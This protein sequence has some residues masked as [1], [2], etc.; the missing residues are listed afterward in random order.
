M[1]TPSWRARVTTRCM[2]GRAPTPWSA[3]AATTTYVFGPLTQG[4]VTVNDGSSTNNTLDFS[5]FSAGINLDLQAV[6]PQA[7]SPG[8][9]NLTLTN[10][11]SINQV[12]GTSYPDTIL[13]NGRNDT[14]IGNGGADYLNARGGAALIEGDETQVV[15]LDFLPGAIDYSAQTT[16]DAIQAQIGAIY[17]AFNFTFTQTQPTSGAVRDALFQCSRRQSAGRR[18]DGARLA[19][20]RPGRLSLDR[21]QPVPRRARLPGRHPDECHQHVGDDRRPR[22]RPPLRPPPRRFVR[23]DRCRHLREPRR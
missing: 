18:G 19:E 4:N 23:P 2:R 13:G 17:S 5:L 9:L 10:P 22:A 15:Y 21:H 16:R 1:T 3:A 8:L 11:L 14:L 6:G 20:P 7:V 12:V